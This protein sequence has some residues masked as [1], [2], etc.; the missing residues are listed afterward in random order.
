M[1]QRSHN[2]PTTYGQHSGTSESYA[3]RR[4]KISSGGSFYVYFNGCAKVPGVNLPLEQ[5]QFFL[6][7]L[8]FSAVIHEIGH[9]VAATRDS[10]GLNSCGIFLFVLYPGAFVNLHT[11]QLHH[12]SPMRQLRIYCAGVWHNM[13]LAIVALALLL[14]LPW[15]VLPG[16]QMGS[17]VVVTSVTKVGISLYWHVEHVLLQII[18]VIQIILCRI[19]LE[20]SPGIKM[21]FVPLSENIIRSYITLCVCAQ[22]ACLPVRKAL[23][24]A[25]EHPC[26]TH[27]DCPALLGPSI[28]LQATLV[29]PARLLILY[30]PPTKPVLFV[31]DPVHLYH[32]V[33]VSSYIP[34]FLLLPCGLPPF[35][36][37]FLKYVVSLSGALGLL[38]AVPCFA[39]DGQW[40]LAALLESVQWPKLCPSFLFV[41]LTLGTGL[42]LA[43]LVLGIVN[44]KG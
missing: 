24:M 26:H 3:G 28:C 13:V 29:K 2:V 4:R 40:I 6:P 32:T 9:A 18:H 14:L 41:I 34:R 17:G 7:A 30:R 39:L 38:N 8:L 12:L 19:Y 1:C 27:A 15:L 11:A 44:A 22:Y 43:N 21:L 37:T 23:E 20:N 25:G 42:L 10:V 16:Y 36:E 5:L 33:S 31:G 35:L